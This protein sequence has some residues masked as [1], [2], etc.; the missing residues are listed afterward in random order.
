MSNFLVILPSTGN[1]QEAKEVFHQGLQFAKRLRQ[2]KPSEKFETDW[3]HVATF[4]RM[5]GSLCPL[6]M[7]KGSGDWV[8]VSGTWFHQDGWGKGQELSLLRRLQ[9]DGPE[10]VIQKL[11]GFFVLVFGESRTRTVV[12]MTDLMGS[13]HAFQRFGH[14][15]SAISGSSLLLAALGIRTLD[16]IGSQEF[17]GTGVIYEDRTFYQEVKKLPPSSVSRYFDGQLTGTSLYWQAKDLIPESLD[18]KQAIETV[19][20][21][22]VHVVKTIGKVF[23]NPICDLTGGYDSRSVVAAFLNAGV[24]FHTTV[25]GPV[26]SGDVCVSKAIAERFGLSHWHIP[27]KTLSSLEDLTKSVSLTDGEY[28]SVEYARIF[29]VHQALSDR[30]DISINGSYGET[31]KGIWWELLFP[32]PSETGKLDGQLLARKRYGEQKN[33]EHLIDQSLRLDL[34]QHFSEVID[35]TN[36]GLEEFPKAFQMDHV[37]LLMRM[38]RWQGRIASSTNQI[39]PC[40]SPFMF[41][42]V[43]EPLLQIRVAFRHRKQ[44]SCSLIQRLQADLANMSLEH[45][46]PAVPVSWGT[47]YRFWPVSRYF[48]RKVFKKIGPER[49]LGSI[50]ND[51]SPMGIQRLQLWKEET[52]QDLLRPSQMQLSCFC[53]SKELSRFIQESRGESFR[54]EEQ[55]TKVVTL[56]L[57]LNILKQVEW[58]ANA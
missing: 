41:R 8:L 27:A 24:P 51:S 17:L 45:G 54:F 36:S 20:N 9:E 42:S 7:D 31:A 15:F 11:E 5:N 25:S 58:P 39:W 53:D 49:W 33:D 14:G 22:L 1:S 23:G 48:M 26:E 46:W 18:G 56:E 30:Y 3:V 43:L 2:Q 52:I 19:S 50:R 34:N 10:K 44:F 28:D 6:I 21:N 12:V 47:V 55:W 32:N 57:T 29:R 37:R 16:P 35:R 40:L 4:P 38:Q 13:C